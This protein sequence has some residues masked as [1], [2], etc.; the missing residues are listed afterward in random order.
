[1]KLL[2]VED[3]RFLAQSLREH[4]S[5]QFVIDLAY[6]AKKGLQQATQHPY[7]II[8]LDL[9]LPDKSG[10][11]VCKTLRE[12]GNNSSILILTADHRAQTCVDLLNAGADDFL[13]KP[14]DPHELRARLTAL[15]RRYERNYMP[16]TIRLNDLLIDTSRRQVRRCDTVIT[17][18]RKE[19]DIL[20]YLAKNRGR[21]VT[22]EMIMD[23]TWETGK[24]SWSNSVD[25]HIKYLRDK[26]DRPFNVPPIIKTAYGIG[27]MV[28]DAT[29]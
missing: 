4:Y 19:F 29:H 8:V 7:S 1:M 22:R 11:E 23:H 17:L 5:D 9:Q 24:D 25:V 14:F 21:A 2:I 27:Y 16:E 3:N 6:T 15:S 20:V 12:Q 10:K 26:I 28:D 18:R 13:V